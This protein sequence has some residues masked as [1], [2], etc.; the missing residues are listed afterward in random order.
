[1]TQQ[2]STFVMETRRVLD[3]IELLLDHPGRNRAHSYA[4]LIRL[5]SQVKQNSQVSSENLALTA[6]QQPAALSLRRTA[7]A[8]G[9]S[10]NTFRRRR[11]S[12]HKDYADPFVSQGGDE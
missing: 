9:V 3:S 7:S 11:D 8:L 2:A 12:L 5:V 4:E 6:H 10:V 1:M